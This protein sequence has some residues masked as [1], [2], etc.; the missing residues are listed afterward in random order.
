MLYYQLGLASVTNKLGK[1]ASTNEWDQI[2][3][4]INGS[5]KVVF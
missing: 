5:W 1:F 3:D 2:W 4:E